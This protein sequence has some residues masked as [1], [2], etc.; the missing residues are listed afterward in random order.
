MYKSGIAGRS[1]PI[2]PEPTGWIFPA[3][4]RSDAVE[5]PDSS[6]KCAHATDMFFNMLVVR[7][8]T[9]HKK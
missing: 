2:V 3:S 7:L 8:C 9:G 4:T 6:K 5:R 1:Y